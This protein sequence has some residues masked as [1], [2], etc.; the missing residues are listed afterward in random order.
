MH[1][2]RS[3]ENRVARG[4][5]VNDGILFPSQRVLPCHAARSFSRV[6]RRARF[7]NELS[8]AERALWQRIR[9]GQA[10]RTAETRR[11]YGLGSN[12]AA[13]LFVVARRTKS[14]A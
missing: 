7:P 6:S 14:G 3:A 9:R 11:R 13:H 4:R 8:E 1:V 10:K 2:K 12:R 5:Q